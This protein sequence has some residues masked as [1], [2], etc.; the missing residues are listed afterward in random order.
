MNMGLIHRWMEMQ[1]PRPK[2]CDTSDD[3]A[4][5]FSFS[6]VVGIFVLLVIGL[7]MSS[8]AFAVEIIILC[9]CKYKSKTLKHEHVN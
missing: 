5:A 7:T 4:S 9:L 1:F 8:I 3:V 2:W 6:D